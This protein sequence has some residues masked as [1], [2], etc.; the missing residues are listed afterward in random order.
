MGHLFG[1]CSPQPRQRRLVLRDMVQPPVPRTA[2]F[3]RIFGDSTNQ[4]VFLGVQHEVPDCNAR[5]AKSS[6]D[7]PGVVLDQHGLGHDQA[8]TDETQDMDSRLHHQGPPRRPVLKVVHRLREHMAQHEADV[9]GVEDPSVR[10]QLD[11]LTS[12]AGLAHPE[13]PVQPNDHVAPYVA[14]QAATEHEAAAPRP[15]GISSVELI[16]PRRQKDVR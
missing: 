10:Q 16:G 15:R 7:L 3:T 13:R 12:G 4:L 5:V 8:P 14:A 2:V 11:Q 6:K 9:F 1:L